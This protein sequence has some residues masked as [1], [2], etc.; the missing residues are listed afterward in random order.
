MATNGLS[1]VDYV[2]F[3]L[4]LAISWGIGIYYGIKQRNSSTAEILLGS[5]SMSVLPVTLSL[6]ASF[7]SAIT[8]LGTPA[9]IYTFN[10]MYLWIVFGFVF[11]IPIAAHVYVPVFYNLKITSIFEVSL[12]MVTYAHQS[13]VSCA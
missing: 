7:M 10:T 9:E 13:F 3:A 12:F 2:V 11:S 1:T 6:T 5:R 4:V 8:L